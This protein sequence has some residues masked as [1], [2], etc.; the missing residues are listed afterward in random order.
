M[1]EV[2]KWDAVAYESVASDVQL[3]WGRKLL[4]RRT[5]K[6]DESVL[7][8]GCGPGALTEDIL[9]KVP[10]GRVQA[11]D[12]DPSMA[13]RARTR[14]AR[15]GA[16]VKVI[17]AD[18]LHLEG[19]EPVDVIVS[20]AVL[21]WIEDHDA[22][23]ET[24][25]HHLKPGGQVLIQCGG[26]GNL[27]RA[28]AVAEEIL[29]AAEFAKHFRGWKPPWHYEDDASTQERL[30]IAGFMDPKVSLEPAPTRFADRTAFEKFVRAVVLL[31]YLQA[32]PDENSRERFVGR[33]VARVEASGEGFVL[34]YVRLNV[35]AFRSP[36]G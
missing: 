14:L 26:E 27:E 4:E 10:R 17:E 3:A 35:S 30:F 28:R 15:F 7:D 5:W 22:V 2:T 13:E 1:A 29:A 11:V 25:V 18:L 16:R 21:H 31:P 24:F 20:N 8:A 19:V 36:H 33:F 12:R 6:G 23:L 32:L 9:A 34:D